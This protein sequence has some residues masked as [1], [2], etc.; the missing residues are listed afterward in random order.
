MLLSY[1]QI[2]G[3]LRRT[4]QKGYISL[5]DHYQLEALALKYFGVKDEDGEIIGYTCP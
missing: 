5:L 1:T 3:N 2:D 4:A